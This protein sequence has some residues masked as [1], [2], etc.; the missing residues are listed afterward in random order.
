MSV[1]SHRV[2]RVSR[3]LDAY[4]KDLRVLRSTEGDETVLSDLLA[5]VLHFM[6]EKNI[7]LNR[8]MERALGHF[9]SEKGEGT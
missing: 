2:Q 6:E 5:D 3:A 1:N 7:P 4:S 8:V 9:Q